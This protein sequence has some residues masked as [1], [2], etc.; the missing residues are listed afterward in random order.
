MTEAHPLAWPEGWPRTPATEK[1]QGWVAFK[2]Q[3]DNGRYRSGQPWT[4]DAARD[5]LLEEVWRHSDSHAPVNG[6]QEGKRRPEDE[7]I[8]LYFQRN[9]KS[10]VM[11]CDRYGDAEGNM[12]SLTLALEALRQLE[13]HGGGVMVEKAFSGFSALPPP[14][15]CWMVLGIPPGS[16]VEKIEGA[17]RTKARAAHPDTGGSHAAMSELSAARDKARQIMAERAA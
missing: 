9:G 17:F 7:G 6:P 4:F 2:R 3:V 11:A 10:Y 16:T 12:R 14:K 5:A 1:R 8:A 13:R 15:S